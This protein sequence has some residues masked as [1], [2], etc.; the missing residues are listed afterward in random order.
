M[1]AASVRHNNMQYS[2]FCMGILASKVRMGALTWRYSEKK[3]TVKYF[4]KFTGKHLHQCLFYS[5]L[6]AGGVYLW[7]LHFFK[8][9]TCLKYLWTTASENNHCYKEFF[10]MAVR[11]YNSSWKGAIWQLLISCSANWMDNQKM[12]CYIV[13]LLTM[14][15]HWTQ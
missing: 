6:L 10:S 7:Y 5:K 8:N 4:E 11:I 13:I 3:S 9:T 12:F 14:N 2:Y 15:I 1:T